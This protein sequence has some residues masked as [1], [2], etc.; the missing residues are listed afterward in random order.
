MF[1]AAS[2]MI[3]MIAEEDDGPE[4]AARLELAKRSHTS[5]IA[6]YEAVLGLTHSRRL[7][8]AEAENAV[9]QFLGRTGTETIPITAEVAREAIRAFERYGRGRHPAQLNMGDCFAY[10]CARALGVPLLYKGDDFSRTDIA[11][12]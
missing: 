4:L 1:L 5:A 2:A 7:S 10:A 12:G 8:I 11:A 9:D 6:V 3:A